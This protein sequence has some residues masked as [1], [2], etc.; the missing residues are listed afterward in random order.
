[1]G[2]LVNNA[3]TIAIM[4]SIGSFVFSII[5]YNRLITIK[6][7]QK[8]QELRLDVHEISLS[9]L[10]LVEELIRSEE[11]KCHEVIKYFHNSLK[12]LIEIKKSLED[13]SSQAV[14]ISWGPLYTKIEINF[15][16][17]KG[18]IHELRSVVKYAWESYDNK[19][20]DNLE[21]IAKGIEERVY[22]GK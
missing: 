19:D 17:I 20:F 8:Y 10:K 21:L 4:I 1:M 18:D 7:A 2:Y 9:L 13:M 12:G 16:K 3:S 14:M 5:T 11:E 6:T 22:R 15:E